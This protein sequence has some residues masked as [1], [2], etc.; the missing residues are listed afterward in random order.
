VVVVT[1]DK[2]YDNREWPWGYR[3]SDALGGPEPYGASK[4]CAELVAEAYRRSYFSGE[5]RVGI[6][7]ARAGNVIGGGD[8]SCDRL[9]PDAI[10]AFR[11]G[12]PVRLRNPASTRPW[13]HVLEPLAGY[14]MLAQQLTIEP[15]RFAEAW[16]FGPDGA[17]H[18]DVGT[19]A[20]TLAL[21]WGE[22]ASC[23]SENQR[24]P[25]EARLL[26]V[27]SAKAHHGLG[28]QSRWPVRHTL[29]RTVDWYKAQTRAADMRA[30]SLAQIEE[31]ARAA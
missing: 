16:N 12:E 17:G 10:R 27:D 1:S 9:V 30:L 19:V 25:Y 28:W 24:G 18:V 20:E 7:T 3:E 23:H 4:A 5:R 29:E 22:E 14:M 15:G 21:L 31:Y 2:V 8:W 13:Q 11:A 6:A 26:A